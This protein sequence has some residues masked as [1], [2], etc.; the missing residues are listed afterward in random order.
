MLSISAFVFFI[1]SAPPRRISAARSASTAAIRS[2]STIIEVRL[3]WHA[4]GGR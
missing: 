2:A 4:Q 1:D 3:Q